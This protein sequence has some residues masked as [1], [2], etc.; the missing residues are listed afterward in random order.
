MARDLA[1]GARHAGR[2]TDVG[3]PQ[4]LAGLDAELGGPAR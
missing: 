3:T 1:R 2:W 4:R